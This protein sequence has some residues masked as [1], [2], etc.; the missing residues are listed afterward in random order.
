MH[1]YTCGRGRD[2]Q[3]IC[4]SML[5][6]RRHCIF[7]VHA[8]GL[9]V[10]D[11]QSSNGVYVNGNRI[12][13]DTK[14]N[15]HDVIGIGV[16]D[17]NPQAQDCFAYTL[18]V[19]NDEDLRRLS[20]DAVVP[21]IPIK[22]ESDSEADLEMQNQQIGGSFKRP[23]ELSNS[24]PSKK[25]KLGAN[26]PYPNP[27]GRDLNRTNGLDPVPSTS[28]GDDLM[29]SP[30]CDAD[31]IPRIRLCTDPASNK[32]FA[33]VPSIN[34]NSVKP[35]PD[36]D[37]IQIIGICS[38]AEKNCSDATEENWS[39]THCNGES[40][41]NLPK[42]QIA[43]MFKKSDEKSTE[44]V[45]KS[46][47][48]QKEIKQAYESQIKPCKIMI[49]SIQSILLNS[50]LDRSLQSIRGNNLVNKNRLQNKETE[51]SSRRSSDP[52]DTLSSNS[53]KEA[54]SNYTDPKLNHSIQ[55]IVQPE[56]KNKNLCEPGPAIEQSNK[57]NMHYGQVPNGHISAI[58][59]VKIKEE[60][61]NKGT[62]S[63]N[64]SKCDKFVTKESFSKVRRSKKTKEPTETN[65]ES[66]EDLFVVAEVKNS[67]SSNYKENPTEP[68][69]PAS[70]LNL[71][72]IKEEPKTDSLSHLEDQKT[73]T[74]FPIK[75]KP[76]KEEPKFNYS[77]VDIVCLSSDDEDADC[78][79]CS[80][81]F[82]SVEKEQIVKEKTTN[83][84]EN[85][86]PETREEDDVILLS[87]SD[88]DH[89]STWFHRLFNS[90]VYKPSQD[91][92]VKTEPRKAEETYEA[93]EFGIDALFG[94]EEDG[95]DHPE[96]DTLWK[97]KLP[98]TE[99]PDDDVWNENIQSQE[100][101]AE[102]ARLFEKRSSSKVA[103]ETEKKI[104]KSI[105][106]KPQEYAKA[107]RTESELK[108]IKSSKK[109]RK[110]DVVYTEKKEDTYLED[111]SS[112]EDIISRESSAIQSEKLQQSIKNFKDSCARRE[113]SNAARRK[114]E[115][116]EN[117]K[118]SE[119]SRKSKK[120]FENEKER[121]RDSRD[122]RERPRQLENDR[123]IRVADGN[124]ETLK[125]SEKIDGERRRGA[126]ENREARKVHGEVK[127][128][129]R[130]SFDR[131]RRRDS[132]DNRQ[133]RR[134]CDE[135][136]EKKKN[137]ANREKKKEETSRE[138]KRDN[139]KSRGK[140]TDHEV[141]RDKN[142]EN[143][144]KRS[145]RKQD[146]ENQKRKDLEMKQKRK[147]DEMNQE[148][149]KLCQGDQKK[150]SEFERKNISEDETFE[151]GSHRTK[152][153]SVDLQRRRS[154]DEASKRLFDYGPSKPKN[155]TDEVQKLDKTFGNITRTKSLSLGKTREEAS[156]KRKEPDLSINTSEASLKKQKCFDMELQHIEAEATALAIQNK[157]PQRKRPPVIA[158]HH[159]PTGRRRGHINLSS[160][161]NNDYVEADSSKG[162]FQNE[163]QKVEPKNNLSP[164]RISAKSRRSRNKRH[165]P[166]PS[167]REERE[168]KAMERKEKLKQVE[169]DK[170]ANLEEA[171]LPVRPRAAAKAK[172]TAKTRQDLLIE[173]QVQ[174]IAHCSKSNPEVEN[175]RVSFNKIDDICQ[176][177]YESHHH[178]ERR[179]NTE[180]EAKENKE[181]L[182]ELPFANFEQISPGDLIEFD[183]EIIKEYDDSKL[184]DAT[185]NINVR[186]NDVGLNI[187]NGNQITFRKSCLAPISINGT[188][189]K[190]ERKVRFDDNLN[191]TRIYE[192]EAKHSLNRVVGK[193][194][195]INR[196]KPPCQYKL[197]EYLSR[198]FDWNPAWLEEQ[199]TLTHEPPVYK[200]DML[201]IMK[202]RYNSF[203]EYCNYLRPLLLLEI[204]N[205]LTKESE[206]DE[207]KYK[208]RSIYCS[209]VRNSIVIDKNSG[210]TFRTS[211][212][213][214]IL[215][216][217]DDFKKD[218]YPGAGHLI[219]FEYSTIHEDR[220]NGGHVK[221]FHKVFAYVKSKS[222]TTIRPNTHYNRDLKR[223]QP[224]GEILVTLNVVTKEVPITTDQVFRMRGVMYLKAGMREI[225][226]LQNLP[227]S[228]VC[229]LILNPLID[230]YQL[231]EMY[232][233]ERNPLATKDELNKK[234]IEAVMR[235]SE[236][237][238]SD[239][240]KISLIH[241]PPGTGKSKVIVNIVAQILLKGPGTKMLL[242][243]PSNA[244]IDEI[245]LR[246]LGIR[247][248]LN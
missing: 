140:K 126:D 216:S 125:T 225:Q 119:S 201:R 109:L 150:S 157:I 174:P 53:R 176:K 87:D 205:T 5:V 160:S 120:L 35:D 86:V 164:E 61:L 163:A 229:P 65:Y 180:K 159:M 127:E 24:I 194:A 141:S 133:G 9:Y 49:T 50:S 27:I 188:K 248:S 231:P 99:Q 78:F 117:K 101:A 43:K 149:K 122:V 47:E 171:P 28:F 212:L 227:A 23:A 1:G 145:R 144:E 93:D 106:D 232:E 17:V 187:I 219:I 71:M 108:T 72:C 134:P 135:S 177:K 95:D 112:E 170:K 179:P 76:V 26:N 198:I 224:N 100:T 33:I 192:I 191:T 68:A 20:D 16:P 209:V 121:R 104:F 82:D 90:Q 131:E 29:L 207:K 233:T 39:A 66:D 185:N 244:A 189:K 217:A 230:D 173:Q 19:G 236:A 8:D 215:L 220:N 195:P 197:D 32:N 83:E 113:S 40:N 13:R 218:L 60:P 208:F 142:K 115:L 70:S 238:L 199:K 132:V 103:V 38:L 186:Y 237:A 4:A 45:S 247:S 239:K 77:E 152:I 161:K 105:V 111:I 52:K 18:T 67:E 130:N 36:N 31:P 110:M 162:D 46:N 75:L 166:A 94:I 203:E 102:E 85:E 118:D 172:V 98:E 228:P 181:N 154:S 214:E 178:L 63:I 54:D 196:N 124:K 200:R 202:N 15:E 21:N 48:S 137:E 155:M 10:R 96:L 206:C 204:W 89:E 58:S 81:L 2:N 44:T 211:F 210:S 139:E 91:F 234:Q 169:L 123:E 62:D 245:V 7:I 175:L 184:T 213:M 12:L 129:Q 136:R 51:T 84:G 55:P 193:D 151:N 30:S 116:S 235:I 114:K 146:E 79:P 22:V 73:S 107:S 34:V 148:R 222:H 80:Q 92:C 168:R 243:A 223:S 240:P 158:P 165:Q 59:N 64:V 156:I 14:I 147:E 190:N 3:V 25:L 69:S 246:L 41:R 143:E 37:E 11:L 241:G 183:Q 128:R 97:D 167:S 74:S 42:T 57:E 242:C 138:Y 221:K 56:P 6:S 88:D 182:Q 153:D 226:A